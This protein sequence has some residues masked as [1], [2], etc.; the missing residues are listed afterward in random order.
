[1]CNQAACLFK[2]MRSQDFLSLLLDKLS[3]NPEYPWNCAHRLA[4]I[5]VAKGS[6]C[7]E[8]VNNRNFEPGSPVFNLCTS[9][10]LRVDSGHFAGDRRVPNPGSRNLPKRGAPDSSVSRKNPSSVASSKD[11]LSKIPAD[12]C[13]N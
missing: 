8:S 11:G 1:M 7:G 5:R 12:N 2:K 9:T 6:E 4:P 3:V 10:A 13:P